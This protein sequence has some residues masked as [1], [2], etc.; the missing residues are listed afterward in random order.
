MKR[1]KIKLSKKENRSPEEIG[2]E[3]IKI[4][5]QK[6][7]L[8]P[9]NIGVRIDSGVRYVDIIG[10]SKEIDQLELLLNSSVYSKDDERKDH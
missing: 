7:G 4:L 3:I 10:E 1:I 9:A 2:Q 6:W 8:I 5:K